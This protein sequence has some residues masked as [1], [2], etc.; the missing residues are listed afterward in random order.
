MAKLIII[1]AITFLVVMFA[2]QNLH[3]VTI[4]LPLK[5]PVGIDAVLLMG[6]SFLV[7][8]VTAILYQAMQKHNHTKIR[9]AVVRKLEEQETLGETE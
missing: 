9:N 6:F 8:L 4:N 3:E 7:G 5:G 1:A 2:V